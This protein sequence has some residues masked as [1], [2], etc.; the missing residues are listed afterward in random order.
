MVAAA[1]GTASAE[2]LS[3]ANDGGSQSFGLGQRGRQQPDRTVE[4]SHI[5]SVAAARVSL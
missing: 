5:V 4:T 2:W 1:S 3:A